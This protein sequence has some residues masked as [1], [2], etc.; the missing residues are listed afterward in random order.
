MDFRKEQLA[1]LK[2]IQSAVEDFSKEIKAA[3]YDAKKAEKRESARDLSMFKPDAAE[4]LR[5]QAKSQIKERLRQK[6]AQARQDLKNSVLLD[7]R[8]MRD[9]YSEQIVKVPADK[10]FLDALRVYKDFQ[11]PLKPADIAALAVRADGNILALRALSSV[12]SSSGYDIEIPA[13]EDYGKLADEFLQSIEKATL[14]EFI[15]IPEFVA[16]EKDP[17][18]IA[19]GG[20]QAA[21][22]AASFMRI[23]EKILNLAETISNEGIVLTVKGASHA[24]TEEEKRQEQEAAAA[25]LQVGER[26]AEDL[27]AKIGKDKATGTRSADAITKAYQLGA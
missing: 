11:I 1:H 17:G 7:L 12:A 6:I 26:S 27:A 21:A 20:A 2:A 14:P 19:G 9:D 13:L 22:N 16:A 24:D 8:S 5:A 18:S 3:V 15:G 4:R 23:Y 25:A 10:S